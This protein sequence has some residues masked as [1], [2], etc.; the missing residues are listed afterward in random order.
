MAELIPPDE[1]YVPWE[2][3]IDFDIFA[4]DGVITKEIKYL[5]A[6]PKREDAPEL[7]EA[8]MDGYKFSKYVAAIH[9]DGEPNTPE[10]LATLA[11]MVEEF[12][13]IA[14]AALALDDGDKWIDYEML[15]EFERGLP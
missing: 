14:K 10:Y 5:L 6:T 2:V 9:W 15:D 7:Y 12:Q 11:N 1:I 4:R 3:A 8:L 13:E